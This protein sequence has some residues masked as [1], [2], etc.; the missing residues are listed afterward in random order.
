MTDTEPAPLQPKKRK[1]F[2]DELVETSQGFAQHMLDTIPELESIAIVFSYGVP[3]ADLPYAIVLGQSQALKSPVEIVHMLTQ[4]LRTFNYQMQNGYKCV[5]VLDGYMKEQADKLR[6]LQE[7]IN[8]AEKR[9]A[10]LNTGS[11][12]TNSTG[13]T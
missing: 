1:P 7:Q 12:N 10:N 2:N 13:S 6:D 11:D 3:N 4:L 8:A 5:Q 9:L